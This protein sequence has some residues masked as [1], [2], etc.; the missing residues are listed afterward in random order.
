[1]KQDTNTQ[2]TRDNKCDKL[3]SWLIP[4]LISEVV[5]TSQRTFLGVASLIVSYLCK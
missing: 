1:M 3:S 5:Q 4:F 2:K